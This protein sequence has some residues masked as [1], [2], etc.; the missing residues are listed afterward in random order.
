MHFIDVA[1]SPIVPGFN[2]LHDRVA[3]LMKVPSEPTVSSAGYTNIG[4]ALVSLQSFEK[5][6][7]TVPS[8]RRAFTAT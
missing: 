5:C 2:R 6:E 7:S 1:P 3:R 8:G 4:F